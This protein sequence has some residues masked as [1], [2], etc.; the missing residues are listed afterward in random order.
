MTE[1]DLVGLAKGYAL[2][3]LPR[4][5]ELSGVDTSSFIPHPSAPREIKYKDKSRE[6]QRKLK[7]QR[8]DQGGM[9]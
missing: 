7:L 8:L 5:P 9:T 2:P 3:H 6:K 1:L 4:M